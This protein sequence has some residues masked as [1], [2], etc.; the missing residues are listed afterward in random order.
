MNIYLRSS[1]L[2]E[3]EKGSMTMASF[4]GLPRLFRFFTDSFFGS[5]VHKIRNNNGFYLFVVLAFVYSWLLNIRIFRNKVHYPVRR[6]TSEPLL[7]YDRTTKQ[8][9]VPNCRTNFTYTRMQFIKENSDKRRN[10]KVVVLTYSR[11]NSLKRCLHSVQKA[12]YNGDI[13]DIFIFIDRSINGTVDPDVISTGM[14]SPWSHGSKSV[15]VWDDHVGL[16]GQ[17]IDSYLPESEDDRAII[18]EDD[19]EVSPYYYYW[20]KGAHEMYSRRNDIFG[21]TLTKGRLRAD[22]R[23]HGNTKISVDVD[24]TAYLYLLVGSWG[25]APE[26]KSW[27]KFRHWFHNVSC[28]SSYD[29]TV[30]GLVLSKWFQG[31]KQGKTMWTMWH[32]RYAEDNKL[33]TLYANLKK[34]KTLGSN[35]REPGLHFQS[36][37]KDVRRDF[38]TFQE[39]DFLNIGGHFH[40]STNLLK[41][42]WD[43]T[44]VDGTGRKHG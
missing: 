24:E 1:I 38:D 18:L 2:F 6:P 9:A 28:N 16:Y 23:V 25:Y 31:Q 30:P 42:Q 34:S 37:S 19:I 26:P 27:K 22:Q 4:S 35:W 36:S 8:D 33:Y 10:F 5:N 29:P 3:K 21:Y 7:E 43:G 15:N 44:I 13:V 32:I 14:D 12:H 41:L 17:W 11:A 39:D 40:F 20:L